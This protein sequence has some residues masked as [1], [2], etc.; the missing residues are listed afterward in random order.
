MKLAKV[1]TE[2]PPHEVLIPITSE[3]KPEISEEFRNKWQKIVDLA[4]QIIGVP[5][6]LITRIHEKQLEVFLT[7]SNKE[8]I[9]EQNSM[10]DLGLGWYC[11]N[12]AG[13]RDTLVVE[14]A[15][16]EDA[17]IENP[18]VSFNM[19]SY[20]G[21]P[22][23]WPDGEVFGTF[24][25]LDNKENKYSQLYADLLT[26]LREIIQSDLKS[27]LLYRQAQNDLIKK[28]THIRELHHLVKNQFSLLISSL[29]LQSMIDSGRSSTE[30]IITD[31]HSRVSAI[32]IIHDKLYRSTNMDN[33][34]LSGYLK[35]LGK[36]IINTFAG[37]HVIFNCICDEIVASSDLSV[38][39]GLLLNELIT[40]SLKYAFDVTYSPMITLKIERNDDGSA[41]FTYKDNG[42]GL[43]ED[44]DINGEGTLGMILIRQLT[45]QLYGYFRIWND[46]G[47]VFQTTIGISEYELQ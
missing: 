21:I 7:S 43:P 5:S 46:D 18:S 30:A 34:L 26:S 11:E 4:A 24:C 32:S 42:K 8:N 27:M 33:F 37:R 23:L 9:F 20:M 38:P 2:S 36:Y 41:T 19:I 31:I 29:N 10:L 17:W 6:G 25:M 40:N 16:K 35:E 1:R 22:I 45:M 13:T 44:F 47:F 28:E 14:N 39:C 12:V 15:F 3:D